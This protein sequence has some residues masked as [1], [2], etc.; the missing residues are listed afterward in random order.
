MLLQ[1]FIFFRNIGMSFF[2]L[3]IKLSLSILNA[4]R[5]WNLLWKSAFSSASWQLCSC[6]LFDILLSCAMLK[7]ATLAKPQ[8]K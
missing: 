3:R 1:G 2:R 5:F 7:A 8:L 6:I 4:A